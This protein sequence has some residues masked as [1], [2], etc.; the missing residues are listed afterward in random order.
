MKRLWKIGEAIFFLHLNIKNIIE[1]NLFESCSGLSCHKVVV[2]HGFLILSTKLFVV[3]FEVW[4][5]M[6]DID[7]IFIISIPPSLTGRGKS[8]R[9]KS[10]QVAPLNGDIINSC[11]MTFLR[12]CSGWLML[13]MVR[14]TQLNFFLKADV[15]A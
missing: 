14:I 15:N 1:I 9:S 7:V 5:S 13:G 12:G 4:C 2:E 8:W 6:S 10:L 11:R 3:F